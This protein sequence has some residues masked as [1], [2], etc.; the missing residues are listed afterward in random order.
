[1]P[2]IPP[3]ASTGSDDAASTSSRS[4]RSGPSS[5]P[6][7]R[8]FVTSRRATP[9]SAQ[10]RDELRGGERRG[11]RPALERDAAVADVDGDDEP[12]AEAGRGLGEEVRAGCG[13]SDEHARGAG[14]ERCFDR[15]ERAVAPADLHRHTGGGRDDALEQPRRRVPG[16]RTVEIDEVEERR[17]LGDEAARRLLGIAALDGDALALALGEPHAPSLEHVEGG[18]DDE[19]VCAPLIYHANMVTR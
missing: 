10:R 19:G 11:G 6:S 3:A 16:E 7:R 1:M 14:G 12:L 5:E 4:S 17:A 8:T 9:A 13:G 2:E 18:G 15:L